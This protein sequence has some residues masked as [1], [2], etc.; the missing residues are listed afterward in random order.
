MDVCFKADALIFANA[1]HPL[2]A[3]VKRDVLSVPAII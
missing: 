3:D 1:V 2:L